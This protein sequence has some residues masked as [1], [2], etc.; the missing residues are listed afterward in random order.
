MPLTA[1]DLMRR[2]VEKIKST[3]A[4]D[5]RWA[6]YEGT[7]A[8]IYAPKGV[9]AEYLALQ[10]MAGLPLIRLAVRT[11]C[12][13]LRAEGIRVGTNTGALDKSLLDVWRYNKLDSRQRTVYVHGLVFGYGVV[14][15][16]PNTAFQARPLVRVESPQNLAIVYREDDPSEI[17]YVVK[18]VEV[19]ADHTSGRPASATAW[20]YT[21]A[22]VRRFEGSNSADLSLVKESPNP[23]KRIPFVVFAPEANLHGEATSM[24]DALIPQQRAIDTMRFN[25][26]LAAQFAAFRQRVVS[27]FDPVRRDADGNP[28]YRLDEDGEQIIDQDG[29]PVPIID[30]PGSAGVDRLFVFPGADT[31]VFDL[32]ESDLT[33]YVAALD[34]L[35]ASFASTAQVPP[36]YLV[37]DFKNVSGDLMTATEATLR[38]FVADLQTQ[39]GDSW[40]EVFELVAIA[41]DLGDLPLG[42]QLIW[43]DSEPKSLQQIASAASQ[44][45]PN[46]APLRMFL[47]MMPGATVDKVDRWI[48]QSQSALDRALGGDLAAG[49]YGP[50]PDTADAEPDEIEAA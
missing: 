32:A 2:G 3:T 38:S 19:E 25:L 18:L 6:H 40:L 14:S 27:G 48:A 21:A 46:G 35:V 23:L 42:A 26:L 43:A 30:S 17:D 8:D 16:W 4:D 50:K 47:E 34:M 10:D 44:M 41:A 29:Y 9:N 31:K 5:T 33:N 20:L 12:Q 1:D 15:V 24:V 37:G 11:P 13:R 7:G 22:S 36:Q 45:I 28:V 39:Y 49:E